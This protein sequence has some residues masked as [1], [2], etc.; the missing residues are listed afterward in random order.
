MVW[1]RVRSFM[2]VRADLQIFVFFGI[3]D[4]LT[5]CESTIVCVCAL[6]SDSDL[7]RRCVNW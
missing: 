3:T 2:H 1:N 7:T 4:K 6:S 5:I